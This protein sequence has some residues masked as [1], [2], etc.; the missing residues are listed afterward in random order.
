[1]TI[2]VHKADLPTHVELGPV[3]AI[4]TEAMGLHP[5]RDK[6]CLVQL[7][8]G[9][10]NAHLVQMPR[11]AGKAPRLAALLADPAVLVRRGRLRCMGFRPA[12]A[13]D[14]RYSLT[15]HGCASKLRGLPA[16]PRVEPQ[17]MPRWRN[18]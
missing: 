18:W 11:G 4:D 3:V 15:A 7:S 8:A 9:D 2:K 12:V 6:L 14:R 1:M 10:G 17:P 5:R 13:L 16:D